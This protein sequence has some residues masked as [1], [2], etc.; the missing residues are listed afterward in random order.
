MKTL[1]TAA[2]RL[3]AMQLIHANQ[4]T[5]TLEVKGILRDLGYRA[6]QQEVSD[7]MDQ[8]AQ[9]LPLSVSTNGSYRI[10]SLPTP[11]AATATQ[12][13]SSMSRPSTMFQY[14]TRTGYVV[15]GSDQA[16]E[17]TDWVVTSTDVS[18]VAYFSDENTR[19]QVRQAFAHQYG[20]HFHT[21]RARV[22]N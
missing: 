2:V 19:D 10:F 21:T 16:V 17:D 8:V 22:N 15:E 1:D 5:T 6:F 13:T 12:N 3:A 18:D 14:I 20:V 4:Q 11:A 9:D 7:L